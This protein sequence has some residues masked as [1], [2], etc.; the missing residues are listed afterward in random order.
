M[1]MEKYLIYICVWWCMAF[2]SCS[3]DNSL[4]KVLPLE[5]GEWTDGRDTHIYEWIRIGNLEWMTSN[6]KYGTPY[7]EKAY[8]G[9]LADLSGNAQKVESYLVNFDFEADYQEQGNLYTWEE[10]QEACPE[11]WRLPTDADW[12][13]LELALGMSDKEVA[14]EGWRGDQEA[15][16][17]R[18]GKEG[19]GM[20]LQLAGCAYTFGAYGPRLYLYH[21]GEFGYYWTSTEEVNNGLYEPTVYFRKLFATYTTVYRGTTTLSRLMRVRCV[22]DIVHN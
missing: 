2:V 8:S 7:Y 11:G 13:D 22:R 17:L 5:F 9:N 21:N 14:K 3:D 10:A 15:L 19:L 16:L 12:Q 4:P 6:L 1:F 18:Q 20:S